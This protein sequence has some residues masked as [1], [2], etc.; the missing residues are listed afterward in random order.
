M[1]K[2]LVPTDFSIAGKKAADY[3]VAFAELFNSKITLMHAYPP[4]MYDT[5]IAYFH[6]EA[7]TLMKDVVVKKLELEKQRINKKLTTKASGVFDEG[8]TKS[9]ILLAMKK[10]HPNLVVMGTTGE[11]VLEKNVFGSVS[12]GVVNESK[13]PVLVVP[14]KAQSGKI[15]RIVYATDYHEGDAKAMKYLIDLAAKLKAKIFVVH[16]AN[17]DFSTSYEKDSMEAMKTTICKKHDCENISFQVI[18]GENTASELEK[19]CKKVNAGL[20]AVSNEKRSFFIKILLPSITK[21]MIYHSEIPLL[22]FAP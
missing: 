7:L 18:N 21:K 3:A 19:Y 9:A 6:Q 15:K 12:L 10:S 14:E 16:I 22:V 11:S 20:L 1:K 13:I 4:L 17:G 8:Y 5:D 2:I